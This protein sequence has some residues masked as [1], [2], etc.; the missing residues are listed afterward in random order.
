MLSPATGLLAL[1][2][3]TLGIQPAPPTTMKYRIDQ[4]L[5]QEIDASAN[6]G[7]KEKISFTTS[8]F[9]TVTLSDSAGGKTI[10]VVLDSIRGDSATPIPAAVLDSARGAEF[11]G[12]LERSGKPTS[13]RA[14]AGSAE[15][16][17]RVKRWGKSPPH[18]WQQ[19]WHGNPQ[20]EQG[21]IG[22]EV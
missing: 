8:S 1:A 20:P 13:L 9:V 5:N 17:V 12:F 18:C 19:Q 7:K 11:R 14:D 3:S 2:M 22:G 10:R 15:P 16:G 21:Q 4:S 6:G